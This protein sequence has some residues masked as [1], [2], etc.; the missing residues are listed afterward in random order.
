MV[1]AC[2]RVRSLA[3]CFSFVA[4]CLPIAVDNS[5]SI[6]LTL[7]GYLWVPHRE[8]QA[9]AM[10]KHYTVRQDR[11]PSRIA[12]RAARCH[13]CRARSLGRRCFLIGGMS[14][15]GAG[16]IALRSPR[17]SPALLYEARRSD[18]RLIPGP[19]ISRVPPAPP[20]GNLV[21]AQATPARRCA[22]PPV[23]RA[24]RRR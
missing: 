10:G 7:A 24:V 6:Q 2:A 19:T 5:P 23:R 11:S 22:P 13:C 18:A 16:P 1:N 3:L 4:T 8:S 12:R 20:W 15:L 17:Q 21:S 14:V 9:G